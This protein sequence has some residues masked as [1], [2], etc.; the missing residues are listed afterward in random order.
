MK[1]TVNSVV[2][3]DVLTNLLPHADEQG[4]P[5]ALAVVDGSLRA[6][7]ARQGFVLMA[8]FYAVDIEDE[9]GEVYFDPDDV[10]LLQNSLKRFS[11]PSV[12]KTENDY[13]WVNGYG[14]P[15]PSVTYDAALWRPFKGLVVDKRRSAPAAEL[16]EETLEGDIDGQAVTYSTLED[17]ATGVIWQAMTWETAP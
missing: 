14:V 3:G 12:L 6:L 4:V 11:L 1:A 10:F 15:L 7:V 5:V 13:G 16:F 17:P 2:L 9:F 8:A